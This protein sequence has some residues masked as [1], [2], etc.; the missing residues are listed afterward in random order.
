MDNGGAQ[1]QLSFGKMEV[2][3]RKQPGTK[4]TKHLHDSWSCQ[5]STY[6]DESIITERKLSGLVI[7]RICVPPVPEQTDYD[8]VTTHD[9][10]YWSINAC[11]WYTQSVFAGGR[12][13]P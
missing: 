7:C 3:C 2:F 13:R 1:L 6:M 12:K 11:S 10:S 8:I 9:G 4:P 5:K